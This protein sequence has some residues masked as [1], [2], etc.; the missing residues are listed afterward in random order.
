[1]VSVA[2]NS[3]YRTLQ[4]ETTTGDESASAAYLS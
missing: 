2:T 3:P 1:M 4:N